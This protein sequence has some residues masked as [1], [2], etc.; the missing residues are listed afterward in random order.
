MEENEARRKGLE[1]FLIRIARHPVLASTKLF[2]EFLTAKDEKVPNCTLS[3]YISLECNG[4]LQEWK[5]G[6]HLSKVLKSK[7]MFSSPFYYAVK[8]PPFNVPVNQ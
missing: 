1:K 8:Y 7:K 6:R 2:R 3:V 4:D 5:I